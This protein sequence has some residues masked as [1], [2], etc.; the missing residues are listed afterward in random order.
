MLSGTGVLTNLG[1]G[2]EVHPFPITTI[3]FD[4]GI[5]TIIMSPLGGSCHKGPDAIELDQQ[6]R[7]YTSHN[8]KE[9]SASD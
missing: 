1:S 2:V 3:G 6:L 9:R 4:C 8:T 7:K 5:T